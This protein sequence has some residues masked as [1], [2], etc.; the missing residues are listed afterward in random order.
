MHKVAITG[1]IGTGKT[2]VSR[3]IKS[4]GYDV[5]ESDKEAKKILLKTQIITKI[6]TVFGNK[7]LNLINSEKQID[8]N[9][10]G[11]FVFENKSELQI[12]EKIIHPEIWKNKK[13][14]IKINKRKKILFFDIPLLFEKNIYMNYDSIIYTKVDFTTQKKRVLER[15]NMTLNKFNQI[16][17][18]QKKLSRMQKK[19]VSLE[20]NTKINSNL[21]EEKLKVFIK[22][23][24]DHKT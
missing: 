7:V 12:L 2:T 13:S 5:F 9:K 20:I 6:E 8:T 15:K 3:I 22:S 10:L 19:K 11:D 21:I 24:F 4:L 1:R 16:C 14:F 18:S 17:M 23:I